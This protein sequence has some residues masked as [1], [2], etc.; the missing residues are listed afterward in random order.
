MSNRKSP[1]YT[2]FAILF[3]IIAIVGGGAKM[4]RGFS[5][6]SNSGQDPK[7]V[8]L[9][10]K[11]DASV[12]EAN[13]Q[14][15]AVGPAFQNLLS[16]FDSMGLAAFRSE[17]KETCAQLIDQYSLANDHLQSASK[18]IVEA[19]EFGT[20]TKTTAFL[21]DRSKS[22]DL[23]V[24]VNNHNIDIIRVTLDE[25]IDDMDTVVEKVL[26]IAQSRD[27]DQEAS[28]AAAVAADAVLQQK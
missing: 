6:L 10:T 20:N 8:E 18:S 14:L 28:D 23:L 15:A 16:D 3:G 12:A 4:Y 7:V 25:S 19:T 26:S 24:K 27:E 5:N 13:S 2:V 17:K 21:M 9:L 22:Y 11:S 1:L